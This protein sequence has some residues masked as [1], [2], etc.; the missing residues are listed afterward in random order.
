MTLKEAM[1]TFPKEIEKENSTPMAMDMV[2]NK[3]LQFHI[4]IYSW[5]KIVFMNFI[6]KIF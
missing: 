6:N 5:K 1:Q 2:I 4:I 3:V